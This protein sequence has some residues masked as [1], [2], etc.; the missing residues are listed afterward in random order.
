MANRWSVRAAEMR[1]LL[2][3][4][5]ASGLS[6][7]RFAR[8]RG[9]SS[10][11]LYKWRRRLRD[12]DGEVGQ[13]IQLKVAV[14]AEHAPTLAISCLLCVRVDVPRGFDEGDLRRLLGVLSSC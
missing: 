3:E 7:A 9:V 11:A 10:W 4:Q 6:T 2:A 1:K 14:P 5:E 12:E 13:F 8:E